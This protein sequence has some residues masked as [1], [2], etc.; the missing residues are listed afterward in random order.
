MSQP[1]STHHQLIP[2]ISGV[3][4]GI[5]CSVLCSPLDV[6]KIRIQVQDAVLPRN[7]PRK[8]HGVIPTLTTIW[9][10]EGARGWYKGLAPAMICIPIFWGIYFYVYER[11]KGVFKQAT[12]RDHH[13]LPAITAGALTDVVTNPFWVVRTRMQTQ[14]LHE[15]LEERGKAMGMMDT[16]RHVHKTEGWRAFYRGLTAS[17]LGLTHV[18]IQFPVYEQLKLEARK[19]RKGREHAQDLILA[20]GTAKIVSS[21][22]TYPHE[23]VRARMQ[24]ER[25]CLKVQGNGLWRTIC[26]IWQREGPLALY[27]GFGVNLVRVIPSCVATFFTYE[28]LSRGLNSRFGGGSPPLAPPRAT[29]GTED[30]EGY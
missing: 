8:Y 12:G 25:S 9:A 21:V 26:D 28:M 19:Y 4:A 27:S 10:E 17:L 15:V 3:G 2:L 24:D 11:A 1:P 6:A 18:A 22:M 29:R 30:R 13:L 16:F 20:S 5:V 23:V 14:V 7:I